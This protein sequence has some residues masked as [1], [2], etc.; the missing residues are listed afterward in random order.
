M[1]SA[2]LTRPRPGARRSARRL[3]VP[4][5]AWAPGV[6][7]LLCLVALVG[8][9]AYP[10]FPNYDSYYSLLWGHEALHLKAPSF[11]VYRAPTEHP[12]AIAFGAVM[13]LFGRGADRLMVGLT[14]ASFLALAAG[15]YRLGRVTF[16]PLVG[17]AAVGLLCTRLQLPFLAARGYLDIPYLAIVVW[18]GALEAQRPRRG[19]PVLVALAAA[20][21]LR[22][23]AWLLSGI[24]L[25]WCAGPASWPRRLRYAAL[26]AVGPLVW[27][28]VDLAVTGDPLY[29]LHSTSGLADELGRA[30]G[31][32]AVPSALG[33]FLVRIDKVPVL[34]AGG[35]GVALAVWLAPRRSL[36]P[37]ILL[38]IG[39]G[40]FVLIG[41]AGLS[42]IDRYVQF[43]ALVLM[44]FAGVG[45]AGWTMLVPG[46]PLRRVWGLGAGVLLAYGATT[47]ALTLSLGSIETE[48]SFRADSHR[49]LQAI[50]NEPGVRAGLRCGPLSVPDHKLI[51]DTRWLLSGGPHTV[52]ARTD[53]RARADAGDPRLARRL[54]QGVAL[55][56]LGAAVFV[57]ALAE[58]NDDPRDQVPMAGFDRV[59]SNQ[60]YAA[61]VH[62]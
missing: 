29:S 5:S 58:P 40:T 52:L 51:P 56:P 33:N 44:I 21:L 48:L 36:L 15:L 50:L 17:V 2:T 16:T 42:I 27:A 61:Y 14:V 49:S 6:F 37:L 62:C 45:L 28:A 13:S 26:A 46:S 7:G 30:G 11:G 57:Q 39:F 24:Y 53:A 20:G 43:P 34:I 31:L 38:V 19:T 47:A 35:L 59:A 41:A 3:A 8:F 54:Q 9:L 55:Y 10:T 25:L 60:Y 18:A 32:A 22:P 1:E 4:P 12:L 23:E